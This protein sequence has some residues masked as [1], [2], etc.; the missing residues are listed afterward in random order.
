MK[1]PEFSF[2]PS[3]TA[4]GINVGGQIFE[5][6][7]DVLTKDPYSLLAALCR[8]VQPIMA[9]NEEGLFFFDRDWWLFRHILSFLRSNSLPTEIETLK[10]LYTEASFYRLESLQR[11]IEAIP[12]T[13]I[14]NLTPQITTTWPGLMD[15]GPNPL[16]RPA[17]SYVLDGA[18]F[19]NL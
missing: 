9:V 17:N 3:E 7:C 12:L 14:S 18:L 11:A 5:T 8:T 13:S 19:K 2:C 15:G 4:I 10:E 1:N 6:T 16:R